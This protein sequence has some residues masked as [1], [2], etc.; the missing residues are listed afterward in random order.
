MS[1]NSGGKARDRGW[2][3]ARSRTRWAATRALPAA[4]A[5]GL[6]ALALPAA[7]AA[8]SHVRPA[9]PVPALGT[10]V[11]TGKARPAPLTTSACLAQIGIN[12]YT[13]LQYRTAYNLNPLYAH[14]IT[15][16]DK[17]IVIVN[18]YGSPTIASDIKTFDQQFGFPNPDLKIV[19]F[20]NV[21][22]VRPHELDPGRLGRGD[23]AGR[24]V[25]AL[26]R[27]RREDRPCRDRGG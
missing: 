1:V 10:P 24:R 7:P 23:D 11:L 6:A 18:S 9:T 22:G 26:H 2:P 25:R 21:P 16:R 3:G 8:A 19:K 20:G 12:C 14:G 15:G 17:T 13:P 27:A 4:A 5:L